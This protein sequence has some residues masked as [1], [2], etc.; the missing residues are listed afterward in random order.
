MKWIKVADQ[1]PCGA[2]E[3][4]NV[5]FCCP[6]WATAITG[7][8]TNMGDFGTEWSEYD[9]QNDSYI[10]WESDTPTLWCLK[11]DVPD[12]GELP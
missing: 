5:L 7:M 10:L 8:F 1:L 9:Q 6:G 4:V 11:P 2:G 12:I 3:Q